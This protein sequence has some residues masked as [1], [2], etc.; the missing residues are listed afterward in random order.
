L[1]SGVRIHSYENTLFIHTPAS[2]NGGVI[3]VYN[4]MGELIRKEEIT[5]GDM[6]INLQNQATGMYIVHVSNG[7]TETSGKIYLR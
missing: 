1:N 3:S 7:T 2:Q 6:S 5:A 4:M